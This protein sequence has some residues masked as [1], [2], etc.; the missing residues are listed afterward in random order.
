LRAQI[1]LANSGKCIFQH[2]LAQGMQI[3]FA[4]RDNLNLGFEK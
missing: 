2:D 3:R 1:I 4:A